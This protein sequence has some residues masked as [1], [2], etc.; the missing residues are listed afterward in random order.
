MVPSHSRNLHDTSNQARDPVRRSFLPQ[1]KQLQSPRRRKSSLL[2]P[3]STESRIYRIAAHCKPASLQV[4]VSVIAS[5]IHIGRAYVMSSHPYSKPS[6]SPKLRTSVS[7]SA[8]PSSQKRSLH[9]SK[10]SRI[11]NSTSTQSPEAL[12]N[13]EL[14]PITNLW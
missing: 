14:L 3:H 11:G 2:R 8:S 4:P 9:T 13:L 1:T 5:V 6:N 12:I 7:G 10:E